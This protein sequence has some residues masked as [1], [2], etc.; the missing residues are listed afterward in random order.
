VDRSRHAT[1]SD[2]ATERRVWESAF[3]ALAVVVV[4]YRT[5]A[6]VAGDGTLNVLAVD[7]S[8]DAVTARA[9]L[10]R[11][12]RLGAAATSKSAEKL[13]GVSPFTGR[14]F[15]LYATPVPSGGAIVVASD[16]ALLL[17]SVAWPQV[18]SGRLF[19]TDPSGV[20][21]S[22]CEAARG[23]QITDAKVIPTNL[24]AST[25]APF[26]VDAHQAARL[27]LYAADAVWVSENVARP[28]G[29]WTVT[30]VASTQPIVEQQRA[31]LSRI[32]ATAIAAAIVVA[33][34][35]IV[36]MR[37]QH[38]ADELVSQLVY[39][40]AEA[41]AHELENQLVRADRLV[42]V[43][44][45]AAEIAHE[46]GTPLGVVRGRAEQVLPKLADEAG[47]DDLRVIIKQVDHIS[48]TIRQLLDFSRRSP[49]EKRS[50]SLEMVVERTRELLQLKLEARRLQ[51]DLDL[52]ADLPQLT[53]D[54]DQ[55]QQ[56]LVNL[57]L[58]AC[59][60]SRAGD[61]LSISA[62]RAPKERVLIE[63][64]DPGHGIPAEHL[65]SIFE[66]FFTTKPRG[67]G[68]GLGLPIAVGIVRNHG[69][70]IDV[71]SGSGRGTTVTVLWP[72]SAPPGSIDA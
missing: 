33:M 56:V 60:A 32:V 25:R 53:A 35:G 66:P 59:D 13:V 8:E 7:P 14:S 28:M 36:L 70:R 43:G 62:R 27:G 18:P 29:S 49:L 23:C 58:N 31:T 24:A 19:V 21:W 63:I 9:L 1:G 55:L 44:V 57:L 67:E 12:E 26:R 71:L 22:G 72:A 64:S 54:P 34:V 46:I 6:L 3:R 48:S 20:V 51:L 45:M 41:K 30:W 2:A 50:V 68:T 47:A 39:A 16:A 5:I 40:K 65:E 52:D 61:R 4:H 17:R 69:G 42:T 37:Q 10:P 15:L 11:V 38:R